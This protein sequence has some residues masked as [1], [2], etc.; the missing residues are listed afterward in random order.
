VISINFRGV[1]QGGARGSVDQDQHLQSGFRARGR[2][3]KERISNYLPGAKDSKETGGSQCVVAGAE[4][5]RNAGPI[6]VSSAA[7]R[8]VRS[9]SLLEQRRFEMP[10]LFALPILREGSCRRRFSTRPF[11]KN[12][13]EE[14]SP[15]RFIGTALPKVSEFR[16]VSQEQK[17]QR[18]PAFRISSAPATRHCETPVP[19]AV[20]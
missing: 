6:C 4:E 11:Q 12:R 17:T 1:R 2:A 18:G 20:L 14:F 5:I 8:M 13:T 9:D 3:E 15:T 10:V 7:L 16:T 19:F